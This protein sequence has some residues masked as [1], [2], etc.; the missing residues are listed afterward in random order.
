MALPNYDVYG[1]NPA[2]HWT[3]EGAH[4]EDEATARDSELAD[5]AFN[6]IRLDEED[7]PDD[8]T[9]EDVHPSITQEGGDI[10]VKIAITNV[11]GGPETALLEFA[12]L[13]K[14]AGNVKS[15]SVLIA[16]EYEPWAKAKNGVLFIKNDDDAR[17]V[18]THAAERAEAAIRH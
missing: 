9:A 12:E 5:L 16:T 7:L 18:I 3:T 17:T 4:F 10:I 11:C 6:S 8:I 2:G 14:K 13:I 1:F 15:L